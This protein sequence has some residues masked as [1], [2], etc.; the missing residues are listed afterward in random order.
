MTTVIRPWNRQTDKT[1]IMVE[2]V[3]GLTILRVISACQDCCSMLVIHHCPQA[4]SSLSLTFSSHY[5]PPPQT[6]CTT[7]T[8]ELPQTRPSI[9]S[10][11]LYIFYHPSLPDRVKMHLLHYICRG[12]RSI[13]KLWENCIACAL[14]QQKSKECI[15]FLCLL[16]LNFTAVLS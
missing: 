8:G 16:S 9:I 4:S 12:T 3:K 7:I 11:F 10:L 14:R 1:W 5:K 13:H 6:L 2:G 15:S